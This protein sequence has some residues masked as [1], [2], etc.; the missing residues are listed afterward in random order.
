MTVTR[1][2]TATVPECVEALRSLTASDLRRLQHLARIR[3]IGL[4]PLEWGDL[5][6]EAIARLLEGS[7]RWPRDVS[8]VVFLRETMR[9]IANGHLRRLEKR[10]VVAASA[11]GTD[12]AT[13]N[14][15][16]EG[17]GDVSMEPEARTSASETLA[18]VEGLFSGDK[19]AMAVISGKVSGQSPQ[20]I[21]KEACMTATRYATTQRRIQ[22]R[23]AGEI[24][25]GEG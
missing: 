23:L 20:E 9:S 18:R 24:P 4:E 3:A 19:D 17:A 13:G 7:R 8:L 21:Q 12:A 22:R 10:T 1:R 15:I 5:L 11:L 2:G 14:R 6:N 16:V 25:E